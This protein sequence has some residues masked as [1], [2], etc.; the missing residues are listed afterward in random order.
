ME[1]SIDEGE[2][3]APSFYI[4]KAILLFSI[5]L[6]SCFQLQHK[7]KVKAAA[8]KDT[9][10]ESQR[11]TAAPKKVKSKKKK[12]YIT[13]DDGPNKGT[14]NVLD[15][16]QDEGVPVTFFLV[17]EHAFA[18]VGQAQIW[19]SLQMVKHIALCNHSY[20]HAHNRYNQF[21]DYPDSVVADFKKAHDSLKL[22]NTIVRTPGR[23]IWRLDS[24][25]YT[26]IKKSKA[27]ADSLE[28][29]G[30]TVMGWDLEWH[31]DHKK[32][33]VTTSAEDL[34]RQI[35]SVFE[36]GKTK[37]KDHLVLLAHDQVYC[38]PTDSFQLR[39]FL[40]K[41]K[42]KGDYELVLATDYPGADKRQMQQDSL[43]PY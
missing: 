33:S 11:I 30:F 3:A 29:A 40:Q 9:I 21:Y 10:T 27:A 2:P 37:Q 14:R 20:T 5:L 18:S 19:D 16:V 28:K 6:T 25:R 8:K 22:N 26:D 32:M 23:N 34:I 15:I 36:K 4:L 43:R 38:K 31:Y 7:S 17:G 1:T 12:L 41:L 24:L 39:Q 35:D 42:Q 13:F